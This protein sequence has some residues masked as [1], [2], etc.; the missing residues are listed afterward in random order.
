MPLVYHELRRL[1][2]RYLARERGGATLQPTG[3]V[4]EAYLR[5]A[6]QDRARWND[7]AH[8]F[9]MAAQTMRRVLVDRY[10][11]RQARKRGSDPLRITLADA[12]AE[13]PAASV[14]LLA[15]HEALERLAAFD[16]QQAQ[17]VQL[18][19]FAGLTVDETAEALGISTPT[20]KR[21]WAMAR[22]WLE[23][24]LGAEAAPGGR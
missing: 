22:A 24:T 17:I 7:R 19:F 2:A 18:R 5:L 21:D 4:H 14:D 20:V 6:R 12:G 9:R 10:R 23:M 11:L 15:L 3:L 8:F 13:D 1:A 16:E